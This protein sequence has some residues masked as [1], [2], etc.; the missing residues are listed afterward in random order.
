MPSIPNAIT[1]DASVVPAT[2]HLTQWGVPAVVGESTYATKNTPKLYTNI[3]EVKADHG[4]NSPVTVAAQGIFAQGVRKLYAV[5]PTVATAGFPTPTE[6]ETALAAL[7]NHATNR[8]VHGICLAGIYSDEPTLT[9]KLKAFADAK[10]LIFTVTDPA[11]AQVSTITG[12]TAA[13]SSPNGF[14]LAHAD[15]EYTGDL[16]AEGLGTILALKPW[17]SP[18]WKEINCGVSKYFDPGDEPILEAAKVNYV[19]DLGDGVNRISSALLTQKDGNPQF[20]D[21]T[22][23]KYYLVAALQDAIARYRMQAEK[24]PYTPA[25]LKFIEGEVLETME[26]AKS[27]GALSSYQVTMPDYDLIPDEDLQARRLSGIY[28]WARMAGEI[29]EFALNLTLEAI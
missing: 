19:T 3:D 7:T 18:F 25:G 17:V 21:I 16:A 13:L 4:A 20:L 22:R 12:A 26:R 10:S 9:A 23:T 15:A 24:I 1:V 5:S 8:L 14:Y 11:G 6:I 28:I 27:A 2:S 29:H